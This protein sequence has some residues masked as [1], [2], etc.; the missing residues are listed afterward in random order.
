MAEQSPWIV[1]VTAETFESGIIARSN[2]V[3]VIVDFWATWCQPCRQL[4]PLLESLAQEHAGKFVLAKVNVDESPEIAGAFG[5]RSIPHVFAVRGGQPVDQFMGILPEAQLREWIK[6]IMPSP[7][8]QLVNEGMALEVNDPAAAE[9]K[10]REALHLV[11]EADPLKI[12]LANMLLAQDRNDEASKIIEELQERGFLEPE[13]EKL[14]SQLELRAAAA[15]AGGVEEARS[16]A[17]GQ[18]DDLS[19]QL[20]LAEALAGVRKHREALEIL[21]ALV[22]RDKS[23]VGVDAKVTMLRIFDTLGPSSDLAQEF[24]RKLATALY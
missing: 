22:Q 1:D 8:E 14:K 24:R 4:A 16:A 11:P 2:E 10:Y 18:P 3:P 19:L 15:E 6:T 7:A 17:A 20:K 13:A 23:G 21:L 9:A 12:R 5:V